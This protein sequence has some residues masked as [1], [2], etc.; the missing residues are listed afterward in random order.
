MYAVVCR[1]VATHTSIYHPPSP[2]FLT[3]RLFASF[4]SFVLLHQSGRLRVLRHKIKFLMQMMRQSLPSRIRR[5]VTKAD[6]GIVRTKTVKPNAGAEAFTGSGRGNSAAVSSAVTP[7]EGDPKGGGGDGGGDSK[8]GA[9]SA[10]SPAASS[11][12]AEALMAHFLEALRKSPKDRGAADLDTMVSFSRDFF[13]FCVALAP[14]II[15]QF[16]RA[17][18]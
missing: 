18:R 16:C 9:S 10:G 14:A 2:S 5:A 12:N 4:N 7:K 3:H 17:M 13:R 8:V 1:C 15:R 11:M 6:P